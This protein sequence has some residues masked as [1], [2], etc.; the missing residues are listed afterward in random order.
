MKEMQWFVEKA[1][2]RSQFFEARMIEQI[3]WNSNLYPLVFSYTTNDGMMPHLGKNYFS[4][5]H[6]SNGRYEGWQIAAGF[7]RA[8]IGYYSGPEYRCLYGG[9]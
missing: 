2:E 6:L 1:N 9:C 5:V 3:I 8:G 7:S 4:G